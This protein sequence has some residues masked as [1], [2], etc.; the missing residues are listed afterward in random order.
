MNNQSL[1]LQIE[2]PQQ[3]NEGAHSVTDLTVTPNISKFSPLYQKMSSLVTTVRR[4]VRFGLFVPVRQ[5]SN[6]WNNNNYVC[7]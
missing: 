7:A 4:T 6:K 3:R 2:T 5:K 1:I